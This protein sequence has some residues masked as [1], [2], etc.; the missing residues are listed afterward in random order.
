M[1]TSLC[2]CSGVYLLR[3]SDANAIF[4]VAPDAESYSF[5]PLDWVKDREFITGAWTW[6]H[7]VD[8]KEYADGKG[9][10]TPF[11]RLV[12]SAFG[13]TDPFPSLPPAP[14]PMQSSSKR[15]HICSSSLDE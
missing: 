12:A 7:T 2:L 4:E 10:S 14:P 5:E 13:V 1:L 9:A 3:G 11:P 8:G 15:A 6:E